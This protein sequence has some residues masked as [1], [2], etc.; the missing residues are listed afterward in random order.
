MIQNAVRNA[1]VYATQARMREAA[2]NS[3]SHDLKTVLMEMHDKIQE[4]IVPE[5]TRSPI[6]DLFTGKPAPGTE[7]ESGVDLRATFEEGKP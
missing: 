1:I 4:L 3:D 6:M 2:A 5:K 7:P